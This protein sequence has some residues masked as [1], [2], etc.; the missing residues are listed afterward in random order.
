[1]AELKPGPDDEAPAD[2]QGQRTSNLL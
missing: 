2:M 1:V